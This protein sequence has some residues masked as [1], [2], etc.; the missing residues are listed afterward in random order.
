[1]AIPI[2]ATPTY[3]LKL[4]SNK[5]KIKYRPFLVKEEKLLLLAME[6]KDPTQI[7]NTTKQVIKDCTFG[8]VDVEACPPF[9]LEYILLQLRIKSVGEK[10][11]ITMK[12]PSCETPNT[13]DV[14][15]AEIEVTKKEGHTNDIKLSDKMGVVMR[16][17]TLADSSSVQMEEGES[18]S[19]KRKNAE[20]SIEMIAS[21]IDVIYEGETIYKTKEFKK[22]EVVEF[23]EN[24]SQG[25]F[26]KIAAFFED[27]PALRHTLEFKCSKCGTENKFNIK[28]IQDFFT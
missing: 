17:P 4:P 8:E 7:Q 20:K 9:D 5:K 26:Q 15:L 12:C 27:M 11:S 2:I 14:N 18:E 23:I 3:E 16:Y 10:A 25:M 28:G 22:E 19:S 21:C 24:L 13:T 1:M 6:T